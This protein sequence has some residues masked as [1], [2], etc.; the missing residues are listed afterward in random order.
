M[1]I[2]AKL[3][4]VLILFSAAVS[5]CVPVDIKGF[6]SNFGTAGGTPAGCTPDAT[7]KITAPGATHNPSGGS[8]AVA[9]GC[10]SLDFFIST[11]TTTG[12]WR[13][14]RSGVGP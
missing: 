14:E 13:N 4:I 3:A 9:I 2:Q 5:W 6:V 8:V 12:Q 1:G 7:L 10:T 11:G